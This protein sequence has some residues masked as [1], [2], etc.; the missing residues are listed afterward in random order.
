[1]SLNELICTNII[2]EV[3]IYSRTITT[4]RARH[5]SVMLFF[6]AFTPFFKEVSNLIINSRETRQRVSLWL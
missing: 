3:I 1:M 6:L 5:P 2:D 4:Y